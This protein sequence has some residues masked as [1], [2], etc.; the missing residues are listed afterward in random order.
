M[1]I[2]LHVKYRLFLSDFNETSVFSTDFLKILKYQISW[3]SVQ[4]EPSC[5]MRTD[6]EKNLTVVFRNFS[7]AP[8]N[9]DTISCLSWTQTGDYSDTAPL[10][11][12]VVLLNIL[13]DQKSLLCPATWR[14]KQKHLPKHFSKIIWWWK[15]SKKISQERSLHKSH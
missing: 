12:S 13:N 14:W 9:W 8:K 7:K 2:G 3:K 1:C 6:R 15:M 4:W 10:T 5:S 11:C